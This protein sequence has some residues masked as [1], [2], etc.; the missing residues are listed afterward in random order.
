M[1]NDIKEIQ[2]NQDIKTRTAVFQ[3]FKS[4]DYISIP[5]IQRNCR[6]GYFSAYRVLKNLIDD[7]LVEE[8][9]TK[10]SI[11]KML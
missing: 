6:C 8:G 9:K 5:L 3:F 4:G 1:K 10:T 2:E 11:C 7:G